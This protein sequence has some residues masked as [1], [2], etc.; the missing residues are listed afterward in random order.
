ML[1]SE[2]RQPQPALLPTV[3][4]VPAWTITLTSDECALIRD[5]FH[6]LRVTSND[7]NRLITS[8]D[9]CSIREVFNRCVG[10]EPRPRNF[11]D[12]LSFAAAY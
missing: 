1:T 12:H 9:M 5:V 2:P 10:L 3:I 7:A 8:R 4:K 11:V 6:C